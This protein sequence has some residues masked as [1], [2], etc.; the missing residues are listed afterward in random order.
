MFELES[1][2]KYLYHYTSRKVGLENILGEMKIRFSPYANT[3]DPKESN[4]FSFWGY[5]PSSIKS[6]DGF[7]ALNEIV[8]AEMYYYNQLQ[9]NTKL[10]CFS[11][12]SPEYFDLDEQFK[13]SGRG[14]SRVRLWANCADNH[15]GMC[16][17]FDKQLL[18]DSVNTAFKEFKLN[19]L[20][21]NVNYGGLDTIMKSFK[22]DYDKI[23][24]IGIENSFKEYL[25]D[26]TN[27]IFFH[28]TVDWKD[29]N[30]FRIVVLN[31]LH[32]YLYVSITESLRGI[33]V[34]SK[35]PLVYYPIL[36]QLQENRGIQFGKI[37]WFNGIPSVADQSRV[38]K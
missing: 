1:T 22:I 29:E 34:G 24:K 7:E 11:Q 30:E 21:G 14:F 26:N 25:K 28:K 23:R 27:N 17:I 10:L 5:D 16:F 18:I 35:F 20:H 3:N 32:K 6:E 8:A 15:K 33:I 31:S 9:K 19:I 38:D 36:W 2:E 12:D 13:H 37:W 4:R